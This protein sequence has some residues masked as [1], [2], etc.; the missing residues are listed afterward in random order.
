MRKSSFVI[1][2]QIVFILIFLNHGCSFLDSGTSEYYQHDMDIARLNDLKIIGSYLEE[3]KE[4]QGLYPLMGTSD[5]PIYVHIATNE[6]RKHIKGGPNYPHQV[7]DAKIFLKTL[8]DGIGRKID[9]PFDPQRAATNKPN[10]YIYMVANDTYYLA[11]HLHNQYMFTKNISPYY[12]K[13]ELTNIS[14]PPAGAW[15]YVELT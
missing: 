11:V 1:F 9:L 8:E 4:K 15:N 10:F 13:L 6:Q 5:I 2:F 14:N 3:Y 7:V 12:N